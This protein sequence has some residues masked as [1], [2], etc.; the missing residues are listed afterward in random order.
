M[1]T[2]FQKYGGRQD[3]SSLDTE[4][5]VAESE[6]QSTMET[7]PKE[8]KTTTL[9][10]HH[11]IRTTQTTKA[12][13]ATES[14]LIR[15]VALKP[16]ETVTTEK[17]R[18]TEPTTT[19]NPLTR[20]EH[21]TSTTATESSLKQQIIFMSPVA[22][23][24]RP[25]TQSERNATKTTATESRLLRLVEHTTATPPSPVTS[26]KLEQPLTTTTRKSS[27]VEYTPHDRSV[28]MLITSKQSVKYTT[29]YMEK[30]EQSESTTTEMPAHW[31]LHTETPV[32]VTELRHTQ[33]LEYET[34][35]SLVESEPQTPTT[36]N[37][38]MKYKTTHVVHS[39]ENREVEF[40]AESPQPEDQ[41]TQRY[42]PHVLIDTKQSST[43]SAD[44]VTRSTDDTQT[45]S[46][47]SMSTNVPVDESVTS[48]TISERDDILNHPKVTASKL[49]TSNSDSIDDETKSLPVYDVTTP[50]TVFAGSSPPTINNLSSSAA[51][52][53][54]VTSHSST[55]TIK[56]TIIDR[57]TPTNVT[58][59]TTVKESTTPTNLLT[60]SS[61]SHPHIQPVFILTAT[62]ASADITTH[63]TVTSATGINVSDSSVSVTD[64]LLTQST[65]T[66]Q[67]K[68]ISS[69]ASTTNGLSHTSVTGETTADIANTTATTGVTV[70]VMPTKYS[71]SASGETSMS[72][73]SDKSQKI[74]V[75]ATVV[76]G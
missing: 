30:P 53:D 1:F 73:P 66:I 43:Q 63:T 42:P 70:L 37:P 71:S 51:T 64:D 45:D 74:I 18:Q 58:T 29:P 56:L 52:D 32:P 59:D 39:T 75:N 11:P 40:R 76:P 26:L 22:N 21:H 10:I 61:S 65:S 69:T 8:H 34:T 54:S 19:E 3:A 14:H 33:Y 67:L 7:H 20:Q 4:P 57:S 47:V 5:P 46:S 35:P 36:E 41:S 60:S 24:Q 6:Q 2:C 13:T 50:S 68:S 15:L 31:Y 28:Q 16:T 55:A 9:G 49:L 12:S 44:L 62:N 17:A 23:T 72:T 48:T 38:M 27:Q 25:L